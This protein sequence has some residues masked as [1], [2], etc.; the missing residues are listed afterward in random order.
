MALVK[1]SIVFRDGTTQWGLVTVIDAAGVIVRQFQIT[2]AQAEAVRNRVALPPSAEALWATGRVI[3]ATRP[4]LPGDAVATQQGDLIV[5]VELKAGNPDLIDVMLAKVPA[6]R[7]ELR[8]QEL[9]IEAADVPIIV[10]G[11]KGA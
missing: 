5:N 9:W 1:T 4:C 2:A 7:W 10:K 3:V 8:G 11:A 6:G